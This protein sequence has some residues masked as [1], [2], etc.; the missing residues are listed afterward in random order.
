MTNADYQ[1]MHGEKKYRP[2]AVP[3]RE[4]DIM[5][6]LSYVWHAL[7][8]RTGRNS[9]DFTWGNYSYVYNKVCE[10]VDLHQLKDS[11]YGVG[12]GNEMDWD[13]HL[14]EWIAP[15]IDNFFL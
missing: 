12:E 13:E 11:E 6:A 7:G 8:N 1:T 10:F 15:H 2:M 5:Q 9:V 4:R 3:T 14:E